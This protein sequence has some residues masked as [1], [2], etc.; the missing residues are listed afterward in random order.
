MIAF[1][2][3]IVANDWMQRY[4]TRNVVYHNTHHPSSLYRNSHCTVSL[5][6]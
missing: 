5:W 1:Y 2:S 4:Q 3:K 6:R